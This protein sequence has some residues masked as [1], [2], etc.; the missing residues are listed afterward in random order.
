VLGL[1]KVGV[2]MGG[3]SSERDISILTGEQFITHLDSSK[4]DIKEII[5]DTPKDILKWAEEIDFALIAL[6]G[7]NGEDGKVQALL[8]ALDI[9]YSGSGIVGSALCM[10]KDMSKKVMKSV[11]IL[12]PKWINIKSNDAI[13][14]ELFR[15]LSFPLIIKPNQGGASIGINIASNY[16]EL[17]NYIEEA[18][19]YDEEVLVEEYIT[20]SEITCS[21]LKGEV[22][23]IISINPNYKFFDYSS[24]YEEE[25]GASKEVVELSDNMMNRVK[26]I[27]KVCWNIFK[28]KSYARIDMIIREENIYV[29][30][31]DTL[32][33]MTKTSLLPESARA[34]GLNFEELLDKLIIFSD[35][36]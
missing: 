14:K 21:M 36:K 30:E 8:E 6:H 1:I 35:K 33:G 34:Y 13:N 3:N 26:N 27:A 10:D 4:Y 32:P 5:I 19:K 31:I 18:Y 15:E 22:I 17:L 29:I 23:P 20:G 9:P 7:K 25:G 28:L 2:I 11:N 12:T 24:K 16:T